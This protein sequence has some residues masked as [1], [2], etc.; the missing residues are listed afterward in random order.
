VKAQFV[1]DASALLSIVLGER[2]HER[3]ERILDHW[4]LCIPDRW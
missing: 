4:G 2:G 3:V 1:L